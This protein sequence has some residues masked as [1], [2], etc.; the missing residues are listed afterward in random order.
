MRCTERNKNQNSGSLLSYYSVPTEHSFELSGILCPVL[1]R[2]IITKWKSTSSFLR[3]LRSWC[4][5]QEAKETGIFILENFKE[6]IPVLHYPRGDTG[7]N[8]P[9]FLRGAP[10]KDMQ[11]WW[12][13]TVREIMIENK[14]KP[15]TGCTEKAQNLPGYR[16]PKLKCS[17]S[18]VYDGRL[19][20]SRKLG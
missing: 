14:K 13:V 20:L 2:L 12:Q 11:Q 3:W 19:P 9:Y 18:F 17:S 10:Q 15:R 5:G 1:T 8:N 4:I 7:K 6:G 16:F